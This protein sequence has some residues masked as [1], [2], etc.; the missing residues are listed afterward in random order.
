MA[1]WYGTTLDG[2]Y[3]LPFEAGS[4]EN[5]DAK[6]RIEQGLDFTI[7]GPCLDKNA[8]WHALQKW[9]CN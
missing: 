5:A 1:W 2:R 8:C 7:K 6:I 9:I 3:V 4:H